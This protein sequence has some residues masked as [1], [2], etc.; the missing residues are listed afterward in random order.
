MPISA[1]FAEN[2]IPINNQGVSHGNHPETRSLEQGKAYRPE[3]TTATSWKQATIP[4]ASNGA[5]NRRIGLINW[6]KK[7]SRWTV[8]PA[9]GPA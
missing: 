2:Q 3:A 1:C 8:K 7:P 6:K 9:E 5:R 4:F